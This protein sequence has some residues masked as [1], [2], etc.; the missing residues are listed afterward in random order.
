MENGESRFATCVFCDGSCPLSAACDEGELNLSPLNPAI[1]ALCSKA[2]RW[3]DY[4]DHP[5][6]IVRPRKNVGTKRNPV[7]EDISWDQALDEIAEKLTRVVE[8]YGPEAV[9]ASEMPL[10]IGI[11]GVTRRFLNHLGSPNYITPL[12]L[13]MGNTAQVHRA[14]YGWFTGPNWDAADLVVYF[15][16]DRG[17]E[18]WPVEFHKL[19]AALARGARL[20]EV[21]PRTTETAKRADERIAL[22]Y[23]TDAALL[24]GWINVII[25]EGLYDREF[26]EAQTTGFDEL[27]CWVAQY[28]PEKVASICGIEPEQVVRTARMYAQAENAIIPW[29]VVGDMSVNSTAMLQCQCILRAICGFLNKSEMVFGPGIGA[30]SNTDIADFPALSPEQRAKQIGID[31]YPLMSFKAMELYR[32]AFE[33]I[34]LSQPSDIMCCSATATPNLVFKAMAGKGPYPV[35]AFFAVGNNTVMSYADQGQVIEGLLNQDLVVVFDHWMTPTAQ[36]ADYVLPG[37]TWLERD[38]MGPVFDVAP[39]TTFG[40]AFIEPRG[41]VRGWYDVLKGLADRMGMG[42]AF[43]W[44]TKRDLYDHILSPLGAPFDEASVRPAIGKEA[45]A[46]GSFLTPSGKVELLPSVFESLGIDPRPAYVEHCEP[47][48]DES[49]YPFIIF[50][51]ARDAKSYNTNHH[52]IAHLRELEPEPLLFINPV[53][54]DELGVEEGAWVRVSTTVGSVELVAH[55]DAVQPEGTL[56]VPHG[57]WKPETA[58]GLE[59]GLSGAQLHNDGLLF[60]GEAW[61]LDPVQGLPN[62]RGG[63]RAKVTV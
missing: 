34:G 45:V 20:I 44:N 35:K 51:G 46:H 62:L 29:G 42:E 32:P 3:R 4:V 13:C 49:A 26:V 2:V 9:A 47:G 54:A 16:Q 63:I 18:R 33:R 60:S 48:V 14:V 21:D 22:R 15:G 10:N 36:L 1:P 17:P 53:D 39:A 11:G 5:D 59:N 12:L 40:H 56:R 61:N 58:Q 7:W 19:N 37:D 30:L 38:F 55:I 23:G 52:Q 6:R 31:A 57:W 28:T 43:P 27:A 41:E 25:S 8:Q 24:L 50:A